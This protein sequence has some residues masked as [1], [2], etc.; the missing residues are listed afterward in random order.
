VDFNK[1]GPAFISGQYDF[2]FD[3]D[4]IGV[5]NIA[6]VLDVAEQLGKVEK[7]GA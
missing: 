1:T 3:G 4:N 7:G 5:D 6:E 2:Y